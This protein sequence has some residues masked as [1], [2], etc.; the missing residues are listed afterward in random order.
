MNVYDFDRTIYE[1]DCT[2]DF[3]RYALKKYPQIML[4]LPR[5]MVAFIRFRMKKIS[6]TQMKEVIY[7]FIFK[8]KNLEQEI[9]SFWDL[10]QHKIKEWYLAQK[11]TD[12]LISSGS[13]SFLI[14][15][16]CQ[17][18]K[19]KFIASEVD[20]KTACFKGLNNYG[21]Q[22]VIYFKQLF[23]DAVIDKFYS[24]SFSDTPMAKLARQAFLVHK[25]KIKPWPSD[26]MVLDKGWH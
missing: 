1:G 16:I 5:V 4:Q 8:M 19:L 2:Y 18:L 15:P 7:R 3:Y 23:P 12:D 13:P 11:Q 6:R 14:K 21:D 17:R 22:K 26:I 20:I 10:N 9:E 25:Q 24:D